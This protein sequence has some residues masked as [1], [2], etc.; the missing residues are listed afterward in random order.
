M[1]MDM[2]TSKPHIPSAILFQGAL[3][4]LRSQMHYNTMLFSFAAT[5]IVALRCNQLRC[6]SL[7]QEQCCLSVSKGGE[8]NELCLKK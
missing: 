8:N 2:D 4:K 3:L 6:R 7:G 5:T 1:Y